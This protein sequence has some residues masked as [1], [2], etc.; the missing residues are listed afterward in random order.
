MRLAFREVALAV[1]R[2]PLLAML[3]VVTI[4]FSLFAFGLFGLVALNIRTALREV[5]DRVEIRAFLVEGARDAQIDELIQRMQTNPAVADVGYVSP[6]SALSRAR[7]ELEEFRDVMGG[8]FLPGSVEL[9][10]K[11][12]Q[13]DPQTVAEV[14][15]RLQTSAVVDEVRYGREWVEKLYRIRNIAALVG[16]VL[17]GVFALVA[18]II[19]GSTIRM[20]VLARAREIEIMRLVGATNMFVR[21]PYLIDGALKGLLGGMLAVALSWGTSIILGQSLMTIQF[22]DTR[23]IVLGVAAGGLLGLLGSWVSVGRHL[24]QVWRD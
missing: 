7:A 9:R 20:A 17:G 18:V 5:E 13:R 24:R 10:L 15:R 22:F 1:R 14:A 19:I 8:A 3:G 21:L 4:G 16:S 23:Q 12:G 11:D 6:D 2:A